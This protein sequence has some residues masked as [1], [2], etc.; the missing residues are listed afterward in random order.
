MRNCCFEI[1]RCYSVSKSVAANADC[2][3]GG[4]LLCWSCGRNLVVFRSLCSKRDCW[5]RRLTCCF[6]FPRLLTSTSLSRSNQ[7]VN[8][9]FCV[10]L[11]LCFFSP[12]P[13]STLAES[14]FLMR[15]VQRSHF[16]LATG[17][18]YVALSW[19]SWSSDHV[20]ENVFRI[21]AVGNTVIHSYT[22]II[23]SAVHADAVNYLTWS[24]IPF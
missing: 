24:L 18:S 3:V 10:L 21:I 17:F 23:S 4:Y 19:Q 22:L 14:D 7:C 12:Q 8:A 16:V 2:L 1:A 5:R 13:L 6:R 15:A 9:V 20:L 11:F